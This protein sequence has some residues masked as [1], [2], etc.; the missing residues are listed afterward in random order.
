MENQNRKVFTLLLILFCNSFLT[1]AQVDKLKVIEIC[2]DTLPNW[3]AKKNYVE[4]DIS[5]ILDSSITLDNKTYNYLR[6]NYPKVGF[7]EYGNVDKEQQPVGHWIYTGRDGWRPT[8]GKTS[9]GYKI[10]KWYYS[11]ALKEGC[12]VKYGWN[13]KRTKT[14]IRKTKFAYD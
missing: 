9:K 10:G 12:Y 4:I 7:N 14:V 1:I 2:A 11:C 6:E 3:D 8:Q 5:Y 13:W